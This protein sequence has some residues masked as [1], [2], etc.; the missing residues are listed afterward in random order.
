M[1]H[2][3]TGASGLVGAN[4]V[5]VLLAQGHTVRAMVHSDHRALDGVDVEL[6]QGDVRDPA[7]LVRA[8]QGVDVVYHLVG[9]ISLE[10][11]GRERLEQ[12]NVLGMRNL[13]EACLRGK[14]P[15]LF[16]GKVGVGHD[17]SLM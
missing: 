7:S 14:C 1:T 15:N 17:L 8:C 11:G 10:M 9:L 2:L 4:L 13:V 5:R 12:I 6:V 16:E 3:I